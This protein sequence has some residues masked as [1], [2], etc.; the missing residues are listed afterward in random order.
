VGEKIR[1][2]MRK[3]ENPSSFTKCGGRKKVRRFTD[4][5]PH[6]AG[7]GRKKRKGKESFYPEG[8]RG[9]ANSSSS[10][11][12]DGGR[13]EKSPEIVLFFRHSRGGGKRGKKRE[14]S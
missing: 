5:K 11:V 4:K 10:F 9:R 7:E 8:G 12:Q 14:I 13:K 2:G 3:W 6:P 1:A